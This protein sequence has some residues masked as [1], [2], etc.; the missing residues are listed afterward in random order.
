VDENAEAVWSKATKKSV[1]K[2]EAGVAPSPQ[3][4]GLRIATRKDALEA[5][6]SE[7][8]KKLDRPEPRPQQREL[9]DRDQERRPRSGLER[10]DKKEWSRRSD[11]NR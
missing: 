9:T 2:G 11:L 6:W 5:V 8:T 4:R 10:S 1:N 3:Q 7:A